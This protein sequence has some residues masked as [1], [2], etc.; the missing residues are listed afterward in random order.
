MPR[1]RIGRDALTLFEEVTMVGISERHHYSNMPEVLGR[2][3]DLGSR[4]LQR[5]YSQEGSVSLSSIEDAT[6]VLVYWAE[7]GTHVLSR[8]LPTIDWKAADDM[9]KATFAW[10][11]FLSDRMRSIM[12]RSNRRLAPLGDPLSV[13]FGAHRWLADDREESYSDWLAWIVGELKKPNLVFELLGIEKGGAVSSARSAKFCAPDR[14]VWILDGTRRLDLVIRYEAAVLIVIEVKVSGADSAETAKQEDYF[15]WMK[16]RPEPFKYGILVAK[17]AREKEY[18]KFRFVAWADVCVRL[19]RMAP[20]IYSSKSP[21]VAAMVLAF[22]GAV[23]RNLLGYS[24]PDL[25]HQGKK[26]LPSSELIG[27]ITKSLEGGLKHGNKGREYR[28]G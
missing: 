26:H 21:I 1:L 28:R 19:R 15:D 6:E 12:Q 14:E 16:T 22:V 18:S 17:E 20:E 25:G 7:V 13:D 9:A 10:R 3:A 27:H 23:E 4:L 8:P 2:F 24:T 11:R 5:P